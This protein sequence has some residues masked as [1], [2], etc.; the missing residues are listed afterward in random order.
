MR[1]CILLGFV[2]L[3]CGVAGADD[4]SAPVFR[5][6]VSVGRLDALVLD[7]SQRVI[8]GLRKE[9]FVLRQEGK[10]VPIREVGFEDLPVDVLMLLDVSGSMQVH[11]QRVADASHQAMSVLGDQ[12]RV[13]IMVFDTRTRVRLPFRQ[14]LRQVERKLDDVVRSEGFNGGTNIN[15]ALMDAAAYMEKEGRKQARHAIVIVTDDQANPCNQARVLAALDKADAVLMVLLAPPW[16]GPGTVSPYPGSGRRQP[17]MSSPMP[18]GIPGLGGVIFG[19][20]RLPGSGGG[21]PVIVGPGQPGIFAGSPEIA[22]S[23]GGDSLSINDATAV[24]TT[25]ERIRQRYAVYFHLPEG[26]DSARGMDLDLTDAARRKHPDAAL[27]YRQVTL[28]K[29]GARPGLISRVPAHPPTGRD[30]EP[31]QAGDSTDD[32][33]TLAHRRPAVNDASGTQV[34][35]PVQ[36]PGDQPA[37][38]DTSTTPTT[39]NRRRGVSD[40]G[41]TPH[42]ILQ[43]G[44]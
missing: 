43:P 41:S 15:G 14:D 7:H 30:P 3:A 17:P 16:A 2:V 27:Q 29:D 25:F 34:S 39:I 28:A 11:I 6:D 19:P 22:R 12:D 33:P 10:I 23:S 20:R 24:E 38:A 9:D 13:G 21:P 18:G 37:D 40:P 1:S 32:K 26:M 42:I 36:T 35:L 31:A 8:L 44:P 5:S 4:E